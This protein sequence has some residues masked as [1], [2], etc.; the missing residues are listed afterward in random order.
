MLNFSVNHAIY[1]GFYIFNDNPDPSKS[2]YLRKDGTIGGDMVMENGK[3]SYWS[4]QKDAQTFLDNYNNGKGQK[5]KT[6]A[7]IVKTTSNSGVSVYDAMN[8]EGIY[9]PSNEKYHNVRL[10]V[11]KD[12]FLFILGNRVQNFKSHEWKD[13]KFVKVDEKIELTFG[14]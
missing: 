10:V 7:K 9:R 12:L 1:H 5:M 8:C 11:G 2:K 13:E 3:Y 4:T 14:E 6:V